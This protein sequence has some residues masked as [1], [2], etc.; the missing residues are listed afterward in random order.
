MIVVLDTSCLSAFI[1]INRVGLLMKILEKHEIVIT[2]QVKKELELSKYEE[3]KNF[4]HSKIEIKDAESSIADRYTIH[5]GEA[6]VIRFA[7]ENNA[8]AVIDD[9]KARQAAKKEGIS[10]IGTA[11]LIKIGVE[12][13][14]IKR[15]EI[16]TLLKEITTTGRFYLSEEIKKWIRE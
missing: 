3:V 11:T 7:K 14:I 5:I 4:K 16:E 1:R 9:K 8:L 15:N 12:K 13:E 2:Q 10:F 6:S